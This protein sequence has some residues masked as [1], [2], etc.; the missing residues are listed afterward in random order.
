MGVREAGAA[1]RRLRAVVVGGVAA[2]WVLWALAVRVQPAFDVTEDLTSHLASY[3]AR[4][5]GLAM[6]GIGSLAVAYLAAGALLGGD[7]TLPRR[8]RAAVRGGLVTAAAATAAIALARVH[9]PRGARGCGGPDSGRPS[10]AP[11]SD[12]VHVW[13]VVAFEVAFVLGV[14][15][16]AVGWWRAGRRAPALVS[17]VAAVASPALLL[18]VQLGDADGAWQLPWIVNGCAWLCLAAAVSRR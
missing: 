4:L 3:G 6:A 15:A 12:A 17:A 13:A 16:A 5:P 1:T 18:G 10:Q 2:Y 7:T 14:A 9:C 11:L 8:W